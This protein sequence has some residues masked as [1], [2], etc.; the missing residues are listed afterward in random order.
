MTLVN[1]KVD[2][3]LF[4][5][6]FGRDEI[7]S[8][9]MGKWY[10][11]TATGKVDFVEDEDPDAEPGETDQFTP[12]REEIRAAP[13][14]FLELPTWE[15]GQHHAL[16]QEFLESPWT[17][18]ESARSDAEC[19]YDGHIGAWKE[20]VGGLVADEYQD[21]VNSRVKEAGEKFLQDYGI[22]PEWT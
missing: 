12:R 16:L 4:V 3:Q 2:L 6:A 1:L 8:E 9:E 21:F 13:E 14:R 15:H 11:D 17:E 22:M 20:E 19:A 18:D 5:M 7:R 10:F